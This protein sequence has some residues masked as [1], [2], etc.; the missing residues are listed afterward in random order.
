VKNGSGISHP[1]RCCGPSWA[2]PGTPCCA[3]RSWRHQ[4]CRGSNAFSCRRFGKFAGRGQPR[5]TSRCS[6]IGNFP[7]CPACGPVCCVGG[8]ADPGMARIVVIA[9]TIQAGP[10][11]ASPRRG[12][13]RTPPPGAPMSANSAAPN[14]ISFPKMPR[15]ETLHATT[16]PLGTKRYFCSRIYGVVLTRLTDQF[17]SKR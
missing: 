9:R 1:L 5:L 13:F 10:L 12:A 11:Q 8:G 3:L 14:G 6:A 4:P 15:N 7:V 2:V 17:H 16:G